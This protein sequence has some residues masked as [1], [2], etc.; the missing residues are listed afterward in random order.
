[1]AISNPTSANFDPSGLLEI[2][3]PLGSLYNNPYNYGQYSYPKNLANDTTRRHIIEFTTKV[4]DPSYSQT[5]DISQ[6]AV[7]LISGLKDA[8]T[9]AFNAATSA[10]TFGATLE[11]STQGIVNGITQ[12]GGDVLQA[13]KPLF[14]VI[15]RTDV[16][17]RNGA[18]IRLY[19]PDTVNVSY[20]AGYT[21][22]SLV[23]ALGK[24]YFIAQAG[25][26]I[27][28]SVKG[29]GNVEFSL[30]YLSKI[31]NQVGDNPFTRSLIS[32]A[33]GISEELLLS[34]IG[35]A[36]NPQLQVIFTG[37]GFR[38]FQFDFTL[39]PHSQAEAE[40]IKK[41]V[42]TF[43]Y[44]SAPE[45]PKNGIFDKGVYFK[46]PDRFGI[47]FLYNGQENTNIHKIAECVLENVNVD[48]APMGWATF[49][50]GNPV[51]TKL[52]LQ[53]QE[54]EIIDKTRILQGY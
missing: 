45:I 23:G 29:A 22:M 54:T 52:T 7:G 42:N 43:K 34:G 25:A 48:Y 16:I 33:T 40:D 15:S 13:S 47:K 1:M 41:I 37:I 18:T 21:D 26:S 53:F 2:S 38:K 6:A 24:P 30:D 49:G 14:D 3:G 50:D 11:S 5:G 19:I 28:D 4:P 44:A 36:R 10:N 8:G 35:Q 20:D 9:K 31:I 32:K 46:V 12:L 39:T 17:R 27:L 51:Q